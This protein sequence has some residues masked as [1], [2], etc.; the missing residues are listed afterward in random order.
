MRC[1][2]SSCV[3][4]ALCSEQP[5]HR[6]P[7]HHPSRRTLRIIL[8]SGEEQGLLGSA[9][10]VKRLG[11]GVRKSIQ[12]MVNEDGG[13]NWWSG[14]TGLPEWKSALDRVASL[15]NRAFPDK[16]FTVNEAKGGFPRGAGTDHASYL[17]KGIP[18]FQCSKAGPQ[19]YGYIWHTTE[20]RFE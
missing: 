6:P 2:W 20:D 13:S 10:D 1:A 18:G 9:G 3:S 11:D 19:N 16:P 17:S 15:I 14:V 4:E 5:R 8:F 12:A 7:V